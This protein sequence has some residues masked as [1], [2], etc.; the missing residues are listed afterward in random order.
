MGTNR[1]TWQSRSGWR[2]P[3]IAL[4]AASTLWLAACASGPV[5]TTAKPFDPV[6][7]LGAVIRSPDAVALVPTP[8][9]CK[10]Q[11]GLFGGSGEMKGAA[12]SWDG[13]CAADGVATGPGTLKWVLYDAKG[14][15][16]SAT[17]ARGA[18]EKGWITDQR[19]TYVM[20]I[21]LK[22]EVGR[23][24]RVAGS[25]AGTMA[26]PPEALA[27]FQSLLPGATYTATDEE[28]IA[29]EAKWRTAQLSANKDLFGAPPKTLDAAAANPAYQQAAVTGV[30]GVQ[31]AL[32][33]GTQAASQAGARPPA[34]DVKSASGAS[35]ASVAKPTGGLSAPQPLDMAGF[36]SGRVDSCIRFRLVNV[37]KGPAKDLLSV[38]TCAHPVIVVGRVCVESHRPGG[39]LAT[40]QITGPI[41]A[42]GGVP[43]LVY[44]G[45][46]A[47]RSSTGQVFSNGLSGDVQVKQIVF[48]A[49]GP[50]HVYAVGMDGYGSGASFIP[51]TNRLVKMDKQLEAKGFALLKKNAGDKPAS[52]AAIDLREVWRASR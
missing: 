44:L 6:P 37:G 23:P 34:S 27:F 47:E 4:C 25:D 20:Q 5:A 8:K 49:F 2:Q 11:A 48:A 13:A 33:P 39:A 46:N 19:A 43:G 10:I 1:A 51:V 15:R 28:F 12:A 35:A 17:W 24:I 29:V 42:A 45:P 26:A 38:N 9:G 41:V 36:E 22:A 18:M 16:K 32:Q 31:A 21:P 7:E 14:N 30:Q 3:A 50:P 40:S 52:C